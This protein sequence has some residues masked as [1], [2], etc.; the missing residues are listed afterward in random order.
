VGRVPGLTTRLGGT[1]GKWL[2]APAT[3]N[4]EG[5]AD[6]AAADPFRLPRLHPGI[7]LRLRRAR[8]MPYS[9]HVEAYVSWAKGRG[10]CLLSDTICCRDLSALS[11]LRKCRS[12]KQ[13]NN[14]SCFGTYG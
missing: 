9:L 12:P 1:R 10:N 7:G 4:D 5:L 6:A 11:G 3:M 13:R 2:R 14:S 8:R